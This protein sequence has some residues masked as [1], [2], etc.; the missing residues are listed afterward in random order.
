MRMATGKGNKMNENIKFLKAGYNTV[1]ATNDQA[2][3]NSERGKL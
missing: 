3:V 2:A 1:N